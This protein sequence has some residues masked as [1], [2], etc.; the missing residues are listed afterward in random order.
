MQLTNLL[1]LAVGA[2]AAATGVSRRGDAKKCLCKSD[3]DVLVGKYKSILNAWKP[4][5]AD[6]IANEGFYDFSQSINT[7]AGLPD[8]FAIF[9]NKTAFVGYEST[10]P[11]NI[12]LTVEKVGPWNCNQIALIWN[13]KFAKAPVDPNNVRGI[14]ILGAKYE[15][16]VWKIGSIDVEFDSIKYN[17]NLGGSTTPPPP[18]PTKN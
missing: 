4:E 10:T 9:P 5:Y 8:G 17:K 15:D 3:V 13:A 7:I 11:D 14:T 18:A 2:S 16:A 1:V 12:P 6:Y